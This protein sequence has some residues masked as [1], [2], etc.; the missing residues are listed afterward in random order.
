MVPDEDD[1]GKLKC[2]LKY[3]NGTQHLKLTLSADSLS[4]LHWYIDASHQ[5]HDDCR[6]HTSAIFTFGTGAVT[7]SSNKHKLNTKSS[8]E[9]KLVAMYDQDNMSTL[10]LEKNGRISSSKR[11]KHIK[12]K[13]FFI[14]H[15]YQ[16]GEINL[17]RCPT[18]DMWADILTKPLQGNRFHQLHA[19]LM[20]FPVDY[21]EDPPIVDLPILNSLPSNSMKPRIHK[22][23]TSECGSV[24]GSHPLHLKT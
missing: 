19:F 16:S 22:I 3:L 11:T 2:V 1:W 21:S 17:K 23:A 12:N 7:S 5:T 14:Q 9:S 15:Y 8:T 18:N 20:N 10:S 6:G 4:I 24:L 13:Y